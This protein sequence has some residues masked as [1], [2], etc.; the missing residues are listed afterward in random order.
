MVM[1]I[2]DIPNSTNGSISFKFSVITL[3]AMALAAT[4]VIDFTGIWLLCSMI[5]SDLKSSYPTI[6]IRLIEKIACSASV[7]I[8]S[9]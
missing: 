7:L 3:L 9:G 5:D 2:E 4:F 6:K 8:N 1:I